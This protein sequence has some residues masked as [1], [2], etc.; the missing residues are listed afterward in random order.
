[1]QSFAPVTAGLDSELA[2][3]QVLIDRGLQRPFRALGGTAALLEILQEL[4]AF[5][6]G[7]VV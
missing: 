4:N 6:F 2:V 1:M 7:L 3:E 5:L